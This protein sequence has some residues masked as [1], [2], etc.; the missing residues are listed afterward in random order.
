MKF[1]MPFLVLAILLSFQSFAL[2]R[3]IVILD[4][5]TTPE[6]QP[7]WRSKSF[8]ISKDIE[9]RFRKVFDNSGYKVVYHH[10]TSREVLEYYLNSPR[11]LA[12]FW[13]SHAAA[14]SMSGGLELSSIIQDIE[15]NDVK[16]VFQKINPNIKFVSI[17]GC[18]ASKIVENFQKQG[19]YHSDL[20]LHSFGQ[21]IELKKGITT[22]IKESAKILD[23]APATFQQITSGPFEENNYREELEGRPDL[24]DTEIVRTKPIEGV[25]VNITNTN[26]NYSAELTVGKT[27]IG[28]LRKDTEHQTFILPGNIYSG[29]LK[30]IV[31]YDVG[32]LKEK[33]TMAP[34][35]IEDEDSLYQVNYTKDKTGNPYGLNTNFYFIERKDSL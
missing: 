25:R 12:L 10:N 14:Q 33:K 21:K 18:Q 29:K 2:E 19:L 7:F 35:V 23:I 28:I 11:T 5:I 15:G 17:I 9:K 24:F 1:K 6:R 16:N 13:V 31:S 34:L 20:V 3:E 30:L 32:A 27:F 22:S 26:S 8:Q 4:S